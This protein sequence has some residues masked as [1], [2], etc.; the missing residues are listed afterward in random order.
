[1]FLK[2]LLLHKPQSAL[3]ALLRQRF[4][5]MLM[6]VLQK[7]IQILLQHPPVYAHVRRL[8]TE[9]TLNCPA[10]VMLVIEM[11]HGLLVIWAAIT[12]SSTH[13][14]QLAGL[15]LAGHVLP[16]AVR[17]FERLLAND[18]G[19]GVVKTRFVGVGCGYVF[20][21]AVG[22]CDA[23]ETV[24]ALEGA[25]RYAVCVWEEVC[26]EFYVV[27]EMRPVKNNSFLWVSNKN[28]LL[29]YSTFLTSQLIR[30]FSALKLNRRER[31]NWHTKL[32]N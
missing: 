15:V 30:I 19:V 27:Y 32:K 25:G 4:L 13:V 14:R 22:G 5:L 21:E 16:E 7:E 31:N 2:R 12:A 3:R 23:R 17:C 8:Q 26:H 29:H 6:Q 28:R 10:S 20:V 9:R 18:A 1:M 11:I 24:T